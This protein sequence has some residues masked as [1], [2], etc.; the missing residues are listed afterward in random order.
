MGSWRSV[1]GEKDAGLQ[2]PGGTSEMLYN[3]FRANAMPFGTSL[4]IPSCNQHCSD[5]KFSKAH[6]KLIILF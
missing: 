5:S 2:L 3:A 4:M 1:S 6:N